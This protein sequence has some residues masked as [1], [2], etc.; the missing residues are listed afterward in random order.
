MKRKI[1]RAILL[2]AFLASIGAILVS[3]WLFGYSKIEVW[4]TVAVSFAV[5][6]AIISAWTTET[7]YE[8][9]EES[10]RPYPYPTLD[11]YS[12][13]DLFQINH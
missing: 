5:V 9:Q 11:A 1:I 2:V 7:L 13:T 8:R 12:R 4:N 3:F 6:T 10:R